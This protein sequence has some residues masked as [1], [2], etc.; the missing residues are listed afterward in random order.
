MD[1]YEKRQPITF[2]RFALGTLIGALSFFLLFALVGLF[3]GTG[4]PVRIVLFLPDMLGIVNNT[5]TEFSGP[6]EYVITDLHKGNYLV[7]VNRSTFRPRVTL[8]S[9][10]TGK[11]VVATEYLFE[12]VRRERAL[13][14]SENFSLAREFT[15]SEAGDYAVLVGNFPG[16]MRI[17]PDASGYIDI[18]FV[19]SLA[20]EVILVVI[21]YRIFYRWKNREKFAIQQQRGKEFDDWLGDYRSRK[22]T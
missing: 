1:T 22:R 16:T 18:V 2:G 9:L 13:N 3:G 19:V 21:F 14:P 10:E 7:Y 20:V 4:L 8:T 12:G 6:G 15:I 17:I 5:T 11:Q